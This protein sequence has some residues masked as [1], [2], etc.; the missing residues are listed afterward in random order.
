[1]NEVETPEAAITE[2]P[3]ETATRLWFRVKQSRLGN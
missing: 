2:A 1:M 3:L